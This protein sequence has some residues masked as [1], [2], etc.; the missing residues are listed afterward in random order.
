MMTKT[1]N[2]LAERLRAA[3]PPKTKLTRALAAGL[4]LVI[5]AAL[6]LA[7]DKQVGNPLAAWYNEQKIIAHYNA[8]HPGE[9]YVVGP[10]QYQWVYSPPMGLDGRYYV[11]RVYK[12]GSVDTGFCAIFRQD[13]V[14]TT[15]AVETDSGSNTYN[16]FRNEL[17]KSLDREALGAALRPLALGFTDASLQFYADGN[18]RVFSGEDPVFRPDM[19]YDPDDLPLPTVLFGSFCPEGEDFYRVDTR[20]LAARLCALKNAAEQQGLHPDY[21]SA[22][23][24]GAEGTGQCAYDVPAGDI[25]AGAEGEEGEVFVAYLESLPES[26]RSSAGL[27][28]SGSPN[29][30]V[31]AQ[32]SELL[33]N[34][35]GYQ[36]CT[37]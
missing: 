1:G 3:V 13:A 29:I 26:R 6:T 19:P 24:Y 21:Y 27:Y 28:L 8:Y 35:P 15:Q 14:L 30:S 10:A 34:G 18:T 17:Q 9:G 37:H 32:K 16:R 20:M 7:V 2:K 12:T 36:P 25:P 33:S 31:A 5:I 4:A 11:C 23:V 22:E